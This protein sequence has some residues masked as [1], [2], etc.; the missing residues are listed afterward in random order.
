MPNVGAQIPKYKMWVLKSAAKGV[1]SEERGEFNDFL[2]PVFSAI[3]SNF[4]ALQNPVMCCLEKF[5]CKI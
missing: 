5:S 2:K 1:R 4:Y 3:F